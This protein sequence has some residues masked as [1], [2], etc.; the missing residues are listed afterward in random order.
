MLCKLTEL[1]QVASA[2]IQRREHGQINTKQKKRGTFPIT[3][4][5]M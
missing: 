4:F 1:E 5:Q 2:L 3:I